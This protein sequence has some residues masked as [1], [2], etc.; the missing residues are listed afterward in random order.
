MEYLEQ[1]DSIAIKEARELCGCAT[2]MEARL[3]LLDLRQRQLLKSEFTA[4]LRTRRFS[5]GRLFDRWREYEA[6][7]F[8]T[9]ASPPGQFEITGSLRP[10]MPGPR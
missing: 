5:K 3:L 7:G 2:Y 10:P 8:Q 6:N 4:R 1:R 9:G